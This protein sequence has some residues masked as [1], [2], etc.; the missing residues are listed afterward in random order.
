MRTARSGGMRANDELALELTL[1][2][3]FLDCRYCSTPVLVQYRLT[4]SGSKRNGRQVRNT[5]TVL[6][7]ERDCRSVSAV[8][9]F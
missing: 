6:H 4:A 3:Q 9:V 8:R 5:Q 1:L 7:T 2:W